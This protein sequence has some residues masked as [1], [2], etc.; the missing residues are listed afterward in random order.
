MSKE[1]ITKRE[2]FER[3]RSI[4]ENYEDDPI[5]TNIRE[6]LIDLETGVL[7]DCRKE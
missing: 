1:H 4:R 7:Q 5:N 2:I 3:L 6:D